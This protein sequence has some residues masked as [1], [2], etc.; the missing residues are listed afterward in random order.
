MEEEVFG[1][2]DEALAL[3]LGGSDEDDA[4]SPPST[5]TTLMTTTRMTTGN[6]PAPPSPT[7]TP[8]PMLTTPAPTQTQTQTQTQ[9]TRVTPSTNPSGFLRVG[10]KRRAERASDGERAGMERDAAEGGMRCAHSGLRVARRAMGSAEVDAR[11]KGMDPFLPLQAVAGAFRGDE[12]RGKARETGWGTVVVVAGK[13]E[14]KVNARGGRYNTWRVSDLGG[15]GDGKVTEATLLVNGEAQK[16]NWQLAVGSLVLVT[17]ASVLP[18]REP[19]EAFS[20]GARA[21][22]SKVTLSVD[23][24]A[25][26]AFVG[27]ARDCGTCKGT[28][29]GG[30]AWGA[31]DNAGGGGRPCTRVVNLERGGYCDWHAAQGGK[32]ARTALA[33]LSGNAAAGDRAPGAA[34]RS[35]G[36]GR[37]WARGAPSRDAGGTGSGFLGAKDGPLLPVGEGYRRVEAQQE[38]EAAR[39]RRFRDA[40][41][42]SASVPVVLTESQKAQVQVEIAKARARVAW[43]AGRAPTSNAGTVRGGGPAPDANTLIANAAS[44]ARA[45][46]SKHVREPADVDKARAHLVGATADAARPRSAQP[47]VG[48]QTDGART[49]P[50]G[51][52]SS[53]AELVRGGGPAPVGARPAPVGDRRLSAAADAP[54]ASSRSQGILEAAM[55]GK[56]L[57]GGSGQRR[58]GEMAGSS[59]QRASR[60][61]EMEFRRIGNQAK[62]NPTSLL[63]LQDEGS[64]DDDGMGLLILSKFSVPDPN[65]TTRNVRMDEA[66]KRKRRE[67]LGERIR[68]SEEAL[69]DKARLAS[70]KVRKPA[71]LEKKK[72]ALDGQALVEIALGGGEDG[73]GDGARGSRANMPGS[74]FVAAFADN[75]AVAKEL[76]A[77]DHGHEADAEDSER[78]L[79]RFAT[80]AEHEAALLAAEDQLAVN[81]VAWHCGVC[82]TWTMVPGNK[83][84]MERHGVVRKT[85]KKRAFQCLKCSRRVAT[86]GDRKLVKNSCD[87]CGQYSWKAVSP[88]AAAPKLAHVAQSIVAAENFQPRGTEHAFSLKQA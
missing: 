78:L 42:E 27:M 84:K 69:K 24:A 36:V 8:T 7:P 51:A 59:H 77:S 87:K 10:G 45:V 22:G 83:C 33:A 74:K 71:A 82:R 20:G 18:E 48:R 49:A 62:A 12:A 15:R 88:A 47:A 68:R 67:E 21:G 54:V 52:A 5:T 37:G 41:L 79:A 53:K 14:T 65:S 6:P 61:H 29:G 19:W 73:P 4:L 2:D 39:V 60:A 23:A 56:T 3:L 75:S 32:K 11:V 66:S 50:A 58:A 72:A 40:L 17:A 57:Q 81:V 63:R 25:Q 86:I 55:G 35:K 28:V 16:A 76:G 80:R 46:H 26:V 1:S 13:G 9:T 30:R 34:A 70:S 38:A 43:A 64:D 44:A 85:T 31:D